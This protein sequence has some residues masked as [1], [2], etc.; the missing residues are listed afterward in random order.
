MTGTCSTEQ[1]E[2]PDQVVSW[3]ALRLGAPG[4]QRVEC[5]SGAGA[6]V[7]EGV[8]AG[9]GAVA[10]AEPVE[11]VRWKMARLGLAWLDLRLAALPD[12]LFKFLLVSN[13]PQPGSQ[14]ASQASRSNAH[15]LH[16]GCHP[17]SEQPPPASPWLCRQ[18]AD[19]FQFVAQ[20]AVQSICQ[21]HHECQG[22]VPTHSRFWGWAPATVPVPPSLYCCL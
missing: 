2:Y 19:C 5:S 12:T 1:L 6:G 20:S 22:L 15:A 8:G 11:W 17:S 10:P 9:V 18:T 14:A 3:A 4:A 13:Q 21:R 7:G 16:L